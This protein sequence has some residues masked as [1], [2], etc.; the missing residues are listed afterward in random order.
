MIDLAPQ[1]LAQVRAILA[2]HLPPGVAVAVFGSRGRGAAKP[3][4][5]LDLMLT[6]AG[7]LDPRL[8]GR[9]ADAFELS[10]LPWRVDL[11]D[12]HAVSAAFRAAVAGDLVPLG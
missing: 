4:S 12:G 9:L 11:V 10:D 1:H 2:A 6:G 5:D 3:H 8:L 7:P